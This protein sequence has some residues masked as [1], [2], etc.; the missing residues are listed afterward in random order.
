M[1][2]SEAKLSEA[3]N[4]DLTEE[5]KKDI[6]ERWNSNELKIVVT[7]TKFQYKV[8]NKDC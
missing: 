5:Q 8:K 6:K 3:N 1:G 4:S 2:N 7:T